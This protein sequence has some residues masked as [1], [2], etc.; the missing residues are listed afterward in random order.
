M[1]LMIWLVA[2]AIGAL[3]VILAS[4]ESAMASYRR[5]RERKAQKRIS[6][7]E[8]DEFCSKQM[9]YQQIIDDSDADDK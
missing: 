9:V 6:N 2:C 3:I 1:L 4:P 8:L 7:E 5:H